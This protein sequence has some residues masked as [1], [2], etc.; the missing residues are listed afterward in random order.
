MLG[1][2]G[3]PSKGYT[4][5]AAL[6]QAVV[7]VLAAGVGCESACDVAS[8]CGAGDANLVREAKHNLL[9]SGLSLCKFLGHN[10]KAPL[11]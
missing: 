5:V 1:L 8:D 11:P 6:L 3:N 9:C 10:G 4:L 2:P 7:I